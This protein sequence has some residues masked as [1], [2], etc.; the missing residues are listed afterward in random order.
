MVPYLRKCTG[1][2]GNNM[3]GGIIDRPACSRGLQGMAVR[4]GPV[5][6]RLGH[7]REGVVGVQRAAS[8][9]VNIFVRIVFQL[10]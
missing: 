1:E 4:T 5:Q 7:M 3:I 10:E 2:R 8:Q 6:F 9:A